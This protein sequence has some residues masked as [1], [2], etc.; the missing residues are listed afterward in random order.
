MAITVTGEYALVVKVDVSNLE[1]SSAWYTG[2]LGLIPDPDFSTSTWVQLNFPGINGVALGLNLN[3]S[4][5]G[6]ASET[7]TIVV[8]NITVA[9]DELILQGVEVSAIQQVGEGV[10]LAFFADPDGN[11]LGLRQNSASHPS[12]SRIGATQ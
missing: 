11:K 6:S 5:A 3:P 10:S 2:K 12:V 4:A 1:N 9:R 7:T 8:T